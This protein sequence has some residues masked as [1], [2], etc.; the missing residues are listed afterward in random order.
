MDGAELDMLA[1]VVACKDSLASDTHILTSSIR[2]VHDFAEAI[3][4]GA[5]AATLPLAILGQALEHPM[6]TEGVE[7]MLER[8]K[9]VRRG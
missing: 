2:S 8:S 1:E 4:L 6:T 7:V 5:D 3:K 9:R